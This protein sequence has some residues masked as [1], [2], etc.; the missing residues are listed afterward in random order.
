MHAKKAVLDDLDKEEN[1]YE[2]GSPE[3]EIWLS[4]YRACAQK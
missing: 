4:A 2:P 3:S 1:P